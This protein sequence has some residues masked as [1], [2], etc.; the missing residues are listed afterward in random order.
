MC[1]LCV[2]KR[3]TGTLDAIYYRAPNQKCQQCSEDTKVA[4]FLVGFILALLIGGYA[5]NW[6]AKKGKNFGSI[7]I[8]ID[9]FQILFIF[10]SF[11][12]QWPDSV[13]QNMQFFSVAMFNIEMATPDCLNPSFGYIEKF[14]LMM[15]TPIIFIGGLAISSILMTPP[16]NAPF[17]AISNVFKGWKN[18]DLT[19]IQGKW[20][21]EVYKLKAAQAIRASN[22]FLQ[23]AFA[24]LVGWSLGFFNCQDVG[25]KNVNYK[26]PSVEC[27][28]GAHLALSGLATFGI[29]AYM[30]GIP[31]WLL[32]LF[33][34]QRQKRF[35]GS[36][37]MWI[38]GVAAKLLNSE[39]CSFNY[40]HHPFVVVQMLTK[41][42]LIFAQMYFKTFNVLQGLFVQ[43]ALMF[44]T[45]FLLYMKPYKSPMDN[46]V[47]MAAQV[48]S[49]VTLCAGILFYNAKSE[50][51]K[52]LDALGG[53]VL[54]IIWCS[55][56]GLCII[57]GFDI[58]NRRRE[59]KLHPQKEEESESKLPKV[60]MKKFSLGGKKKDIEKTSETKDNSKAE[61]KPVKEE[62]GENAE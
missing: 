6:V 3:K 57:I 37:A 54:A 16:F 31:I 22:L 60:N 7:R 40:Q 11:K 36:T 27:G 18:K 17:I 10:G 29:I 49:I 21:V 20:D 12:L 13:A 28:T 14:T 5:M 24:S 25:G 35:T 2:T 8:L 43:I 61:E 39:N 47:D 50:G 38:K 51:I 56:I 58:R 53:V 41:A 55:I 33:Y 45:G 1:N 46:T 26:D 42:F 52:G 23:F 32:T 30:A 15:V 48:S 44:Y 4:I 62:K 19:P 9:Y 34:L 59:S